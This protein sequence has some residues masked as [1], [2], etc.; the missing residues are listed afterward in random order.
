MI[1]VNKRVTISFNIRTLHATSQDEIMTELYDYGQYLHLNE[2]MYLCRPSEV[3]PVVEQVVKVSVLASLQHLAN[4][5]F[6][7]L[8]MSGLKL[9]KLE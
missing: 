5:Y 4:S 3:R 6:P 9:L 1:N 8:S 7:R 2:I